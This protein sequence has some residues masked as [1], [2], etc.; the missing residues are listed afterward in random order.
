MNKFSY[1]LK[2][3]CENKKSLEN[4]PRKKNEALTNLTN[5]LEYFERLVRLEF[6][7]A[8]FI[9][10]VRQ[11]D[12]FKCVNNIGELSIMHV[13]TEKV[14]SLWF[15]LLAYQ[16]GIDLTSADRECWK[17]IFGEESSETEVE[18]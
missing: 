16:I 5:S 4:W 11:D 18:K 14:C 15:D 8:N 2:K 10:D 9:D 12:R 1:F 6:Q 13:E 3:T 7:L 17:N